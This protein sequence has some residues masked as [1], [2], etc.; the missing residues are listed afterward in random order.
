MAAVDAD[1]AHG[2]LADRL[3]EDVRGGQR[4]CRDVAGQ[5][6]PA[7]RARERKDHPQAVHAGS[8]CPSGL[9][10]RADYGWTV[11]VKPGGSGGTE[12]DPVAPGTATCAGPVTGWPDAVLTEAETWAAGCEG[13]LGVVAVFVTGG[14]AADEDADEVEAAFFGAA[15]G[16]V[17]V[18]GGAGD[19]GARRLIFAGAATD[20]VFTDVVC[21]TG[22]A[23]SEAP[24]TARV[25]V[26]RLLAG[27][28]GSR[29]S[30]AADWPRACVCRGR[31]GATRRGT[32]AFGFDSWAGLTSTPTEGRGREGLLFPG[33]TRAWATGVGSTSCVTAVPTW[34]LTVASPA[35]ARERP[36]AGATSSFAVAAEGMTGRERT[37]PMLPR[38]DRSGAAADP[39][40]RLARESSRRA[41]DGES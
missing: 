29:R 3:D 38:I 8:L 6:E 2:S 33:A 35:R 32:A 23:A 27:G 34:A 26:V 9:G 41:Q 11:A 20:R 15:S 12:A 25:K 7:D 1:P 21:V 18:R 24:M 31:A 4:P 17:G 30:L 37:T 36:I 10:L 5:A 19:C 28:L 22:A 39:R 40:S 13:L 16:F 14:C